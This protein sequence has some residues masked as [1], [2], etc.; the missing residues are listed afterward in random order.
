M[1]RLSADLGMSV[2]VEGIET[3]E[4]LDLV[5]RERNVDEAQGFLI[6]VP[7]PAEDIRRML[8][9]DRADARVA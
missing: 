6:G 3:E 9:S 8:L 7:M 5:A 1:A 4:Q 2:A